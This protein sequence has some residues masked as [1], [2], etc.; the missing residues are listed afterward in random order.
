MRRTVRSLLGLLLLATLLAPSPSAA[1]AEGPIYLV[2]EGDTVIAIADRFGSSVD[3]I[4]RAN[5]LADP[6]RISPGMAL[7]I[8]GFP[9]VSGVLETRSLAFGENLESLR[10]RYGIPTEALVRLNRVIHPERV[11]AGE[12]W[13]VAVADEHEGGGEFRPAQPG[14]GLI[15]ESAAAGV[16]P[17]QEAAFLEQPYRRWFVPGDPIVWPADAGPTIAL[18]R[19]AI[20]IELEPTP[21]VQGKTA[22]L[23]L[24]L[25]EPAEVEAIW[26]GRP[27]AFHTLEDGSRLGL[28][29]IHAL[30][31]PGVQDVELT[32]RTQDGLEVR[33]HQPVRVISGGYG[34][35]PVL[36]VPAETLDP[37]FTGP[38]DEMIRSLLAQVTPDR[39]WE[40]AFEAPSTGSYTSRF[41]SRRNYNN[42]GY[43]SYHSGLDFSGRSGV[44]ILAPARGRVVFA[45]L[46]QV[47]GNTTFIDHGWGVFSGY[48]HQSEILVEVGQIVE[49]GDT[50]GL[51]GGTGRVTGPHLHWEVWVNGIAVDPIQWLEE[52]FP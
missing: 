18:P 43:L 51:V 34:S 52:V 50:V 17:W 15:Q 20:E 37:A 10:V 48:L 21:V 3:A 28:Q 12:E 11:H 33:Y 49:T 39:L 7:V 22:V 5:G 25:S 24:R 19:P 41:G 31:D 1:Q 13:V 6:S 4:A 23:R 45:G 14:R 26:D 47:R 29:G 2:Q 38:E 8:P 36:Y 27:L 42:T 40:G 16:N 46:L 9:G 32:L 44:P 35:D 30:A